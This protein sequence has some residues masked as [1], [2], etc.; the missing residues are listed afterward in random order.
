[1]ILN[2]CTSVLLAICDIKDEEKA[3]KTHALMIN[4]LDIDNLIQKML[5]IYTFKIGGNETKRRAYEY[6]IMCT[7]YEESSIG[8]ENRC[9]ENEF[10]EFGHMI[11]R[12]LTTIQTGFNIYQILLIFQRTHRDH[13]KMERFLRNEEE[14]IY[15]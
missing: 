4:E 12:D 3:A 9:I 11:P 10:C 1:M 6:S 2:S 5:D 8:N 7:H 13:P 14:F 15:L